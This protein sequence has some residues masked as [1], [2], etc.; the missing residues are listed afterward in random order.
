[1]RKLSEVMNE[2]H[3][4]HREKGVLCLIGNIVLVP[5]KLG[6]MVKNEVLEV[7]VR[8]LKANYVM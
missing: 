7:F 3:T 4:T 6:S 5:P 8:Q 2:S 1:M